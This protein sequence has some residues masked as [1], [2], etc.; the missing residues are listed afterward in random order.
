MMRRRTQRRESGPSEVPLQER[1]SIEHT[2]RIV[3]TRDL[4]VVR[5]AAGQLH[6]GR[7]HS[8]ERDTGRLGP[9]GEREQRPLVRAADTAR[10]GFTRQHHDDQQRQGRAHQ[11]GA[12]HQICVFWGMWLRSLPIFGAR[13][14][15]R[16]HGVD[17]GEHP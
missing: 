11:N 4:G 1:A 10:S 17:G 14:R 7:R 15:F 8:V 6:G 12:W 3:V 13:H 5:Q 16:E 9:L 2:E